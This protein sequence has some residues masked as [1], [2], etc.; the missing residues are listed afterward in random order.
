M[1]E[2]FAGWRS[3]GL[4]VTR[5]KTVF[6]GL[7]SI[8]LAAV[9]AKPASAISN[10]VVDIYGSYTDGVSGVTAG[11]NAPTISLSGGLQNTDYFN[12]DNL[13]Q[14]GSAEYANGDSNGLLFTVDPAS[15]ISGSRSGCQ[16]NTG[17]EKADI[18]VDFTFYN[19]KGVVIGTASDTAVATFNY[20]SNPNNDDDNLCWMN[21]SV[22][23]TAVVS[24]K[25]I[26]TCGAPG[27][28]LQT[29]YE[30]IEVDLNGAYYDVNLYDWNDWDEQPTVT[31]QSIRPPTE[32]PEPASFALLAAGL[33]GL[34]LVAARQRRVKAEVV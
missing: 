28:G 26:G 19:S 16:T 22:G 31:F 12:V 14:G 21:S 3:K 32:A 4:S 13:T 33:L 23:G 20:F 8:A 34:G 25:L 9:L 30:Q 27:T 15:C 2:I 5:G 29:A 1:V 10:P 6:A 18:S 24:S 11:D 7:F 17:T